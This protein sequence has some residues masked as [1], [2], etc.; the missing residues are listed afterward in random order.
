MDLGM[1]RERAHDGKRHAD[2]AQGSGSTHQDLLH[3]TLALEGCGRSSRQEGEPD[4]HRAVAED[5]LHVQRRDE[6]LR[7]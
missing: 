4:F 6:E 1:R 2:I 7:E 3:V 5:E